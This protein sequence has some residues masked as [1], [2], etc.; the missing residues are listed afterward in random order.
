MR[1]HPRSKRFN[2]PQFDLHLQSPEKW[3]GD[4][5]DHINIWLQGATELGV[6]LSFDS[7]IPFTHSIFGEFTVFTGFWHYI[8]TTERDDLLRGMWGRRL[9]EYSKRLTRCIVPNFQ[10]IILD[11]NWQRIQQHP[12]LMKAMEESTLPFDSYSINP[13][14]HL[15]KRAPYY[16]WFIAGCEETRKALKEN[17]AP[18]WSKFLTTPTNDIYEAVRPKPIVPQTVLATKNN[19]LL[20]AIRQKQHHTD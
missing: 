4:G 2:Q 9:D 3:Q 11:A 16:N 7:Q 6:C 17:R 12:V 15:W 18:D 1:H 5:V 10:A 13:D 19:Q 8:K 14:T 20:K